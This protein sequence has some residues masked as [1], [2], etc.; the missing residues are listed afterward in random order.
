MPMASG[1]LTSMMSEIA[2]RHWEA[3]QRMDTQPASLNEENTW[4]AASDQELQVIAQV[5]TLIQPLSEAERRR[6]VVYLAARNGVY[7]R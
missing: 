4:T 1:I 6:I 7:V 2:S 5:L 3:Q